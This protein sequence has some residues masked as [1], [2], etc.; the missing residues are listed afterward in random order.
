MST[1]VKESLN[2]PGQTLR[3]PVGRESQSAD[4]SDKFAE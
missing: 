3:V 2:R 1:R 4:E